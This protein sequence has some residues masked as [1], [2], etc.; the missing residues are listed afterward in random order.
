[1]EGGDEKTWVQPW[2]GVNNI[3]D[4]PNFHTIIITFFILVSGF[5]FIWYTER[6]LSIIM[7]DEIPEE[8]RVNIV[9]GIL[10]EHFPDLPTAVIRNSFDEEQCQTHDVLVDLQMFAET[11]VTRL[12]ALSEAI[13][14]STASITA[15]SNLEVLQNAPHSGNSGTNSYSLRLNDELKGIP[16]F[17]PDTLTL[18]CFEWLSIFES[19]VDPLNLNTNLYFS[20]FRNKLEGRAGLWM[21]QTTN[22]FYIKDNEDT[23][24]TKTSAPEINFVQNAIQLLKQTFSQEFDT[25]NPIRY[26]I[27]YTNWQQRTDTPNEHYLK[28]SKMH[29]RAEM[30]GC[31]DLLPLCAK[32]KTS[33]DS[34]LQDWIIL[35]NKWD[36]PLRQLKEEVQDHHV[37]S[38]KLSGSSKSQTTAPQKSSNSSSSHGSLSKAQRHYCPHHKRDVYHKPEDCYLGKRVAQD[39]SQDKGGSSFKLGPDSKCISIDIEIDGAPHEMIID[40]GGAR[41]IISS[42]FSRA[43][44]LHVHPL[45]HPVSLLTADDHP[46]S[47]VGQ[48]NVDFYV[49]L[50][51]TFVTCS[52][53]VVDSDEERILLGTPDFHHFPNLLIDMN[54]KTI[55]LKPELPADPSLGETASDDCLPLDSLLSSV[56]SPEEVSIPEDWDEMNYPKEVIDPTPH[57]DYD[58]TSI[59]TDPTEIERLKSF[60]PIFVEF[61]DVFSATPN[62][63]T[64]SS[65]PPYHIKVRDPDCFHREKPRPVPR[66]MWDDWCKIRD[67]MLEA[68]IIKRSDSPCCSPMFFKYKKSGHGKKLQAM[69]DYRGAN[70]NLLFDPYPSPDAEGIILRFAHFKFFII[71]DLASG[72]YQIKLS[73]DSTKWTAFS[74]GVELFEALVLFFGI[75]PAPAALHRGMNFVFDGVL[76]DNVAI[77]MDDLIIGADSED[78]ALDFLRVV[79]LRA[80]EHNLSFKPSK[81]QF[82]LEEVEFLGYTLKGG[83]IFPTRQKIEALDHLLSITSLT[84]LRRFYG[85]ANYMSTNIPR[86][87][88][89]SKP[90]SDVMSTAT[91]KWGEEQKEAASKIVSVLQSKPC[92][93]G[94]IPHHTYL[95]EVDASA[96]GVGGILCQVPVPPELEEEDHQA[97]LDE[98]MNCYRSKDVTTTSYYQRPFTSSETNLSPTELEFCGLIYVVRRFWKWLYGQPFVVLTDHKAL[99]SLWESSSPAGR[100]GRWLQDVQEMSPSIVYIPGKENVRADAIS[101]IKPPSQDTDD[102]MLMI[103][104]AEFDFF[105]EGD[106]IDSD[107]DEV[108]GEEEDEDFDLSFEYLRALQQDDPQLGPVIEYLEE[109]YLSTTKPEAQATKSRAQNCQMVNGIV[110]TQDGLIYVPLSLRIFIIRQYHSS[111][112]S[113]HMGRNGT[114][115]KIKQKYSWPGMTSDVNKYIQ[116]CEICHVHSLK[117]EERAPQKRIPPP[118]LPFTRVA[119]DFLGPF[120][121]TP[122]GHKYI[123]VFVDYTTH[124]PV[125][126]ATKTQSAE[127][128][129][130]CMLNCFTT[131][132]FPSILQSDQGRS[133][134]ANS[135]MSLLRIM[136]VDQRRTS[137]FNPRCNGKVERMNRTLLQLLKKYT[138]EIPTTWDVA[139]DLALFAYRC[140]PHSVTLYSPHF[141]RFGVHPTLPFESELDS[142]EIE[143]NAFAQQ[144][145]HNLSRAW[146]LAGNRLAANHASSTLQSSHPT[147]NIGDEVMVY[148]PNSK[149]DK[150]GSVWIGPFKVHSKKSDTLYEINFGPT[151][152]RSRIRNIHNL[153]PASAQIPTPPTLPSPEDEDEETKDSSPQY[154]TRSGRVSKPPH[155]L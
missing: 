108:K 68:G 12:T 79:F 119:V 1:V 105:L 125:A 111:I 114:A 55:V 59:F 41:S 58:L 4:N 135:V 3:C 77:L 67:G 142:S 56:I 131:H 81:V 139:L 98:C 136:S 100:V 101:R 65:I 49:P 118:P 129:A 133:F 15:Q 134:L 146:A 74:D 29:R 30:R 109:G 10:T 57:V 45:E 147:F 70:E 93:Q 126:Y 38:Q 85:L 112:F 17:D 34:S 130:R 104:D 64:I 63:P 87:G 86:W 39:S 2:V 14:V 18:D 36:L 91:F 140:T 53:L 51:S 95:I 27:Q 31:K 37:I 124:Y 84:D 82:L 22:E 44:G 8:L 94:I 33:L 50:S 11:Q 141:L 90:L 122:E 151:S 116:Q 71:L 145:Y 5:Y 19:I 83:N 88:E 154:K 46:I 48:V 149:K 138:D 78:E 99:V 103:C 32:F 72:F 61:E 128:V 92:I 110:H 75:K 24:E 69:C 35:N 73:D 143:I 150:L 117:Q 25:V 76:G 144:Q 121:V 153:R 20:C 54:E 6:D 40:T 148:D 9:M 97:W 127:E 123:L 106:D 21:A 26:Q 23:E 152:R 28:L 102:E 47:C 16:V 115:N 113:G 155:R 96:R 120:P 107:E 137:P 60:H 62:T 13:N 42:S 132:G 7:G 89:L 66:H 80:R 52:F 43:L